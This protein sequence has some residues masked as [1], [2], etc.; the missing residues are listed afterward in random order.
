[1]PCYASASMNT[2]VR[3]LPLR[4]PP[5]YGVYPRGW[6]PGM[7]FFIPFSDQKL[8]DRFEVGAEGISYFLGA[9]M[10]FYVGKNMDPLRIS[11]E[12]LQKWSDAGNSAPAW[13]L[14]VGGSTSAGIVTFGNTYLWTRSRKDNEGVRLCQRQ[15]KHS[16]DNTEYRRTRTCGRWQCFGGSRRRVV[17]TELGPVASE[18]YQSW[19]C[20]QRWKQ[21][22]ENKEPTRGRLSACS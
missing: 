3:P 18:S 10:V 7:V 14:D 15:H 16:F 5:R 20:P 13:T 21:D 12:V 19:C 2:D 17:G 11:S 9:N 1:M 4:G 22:A 8:A 6:K